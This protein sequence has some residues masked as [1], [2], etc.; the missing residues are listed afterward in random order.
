[1]SKIICIRNHSTYHR[2]DHMCVITVCNITYHLFVMGS[3]LS[4]YKVQILHKAY[5]TISNPPILMVKDLISPPYYHFAKV[6]VALNVVTIHFRLNK[7]IQQN[8]GLQC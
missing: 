8:S 6:G 5:M 4:Q 3:I 7:S 2:I 1:M